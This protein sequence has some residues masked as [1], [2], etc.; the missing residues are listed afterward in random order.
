LCVHEKRYPFSESAGYRHWTRKAGPVADEAIEH[1][2]IV[3]TRKG[4]KT[5][6]CG[7]AERNAIARMALLS[8]R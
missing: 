6:R 1:P 5:N 8:R 7:V 4:T 3:E 2:M